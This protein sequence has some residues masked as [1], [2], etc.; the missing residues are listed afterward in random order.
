MINNIAYIN[1]ELPSSH[2][3]TFNDGLKYGLFGEVQYKCS[4][5][6]TATCFAS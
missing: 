5:S 3:I 6:W 1:F 2:G 4:S